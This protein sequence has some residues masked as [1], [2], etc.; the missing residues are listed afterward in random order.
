MLVV[1]S[2]IFVTDTKIISTH[3]FVVPLKMYLKELRKKM[4]FLGLFSF[5]S[6]NRTIQA[7]LYQINNNLKLILMHTVKNINFDL[8][9]QGWLYLLKRSYV[10]C[11]II[12]ITVPLNYLRNQNILNTSDILV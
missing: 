7:T 2:L 11:Y 9:I 3:D 6:F 10:C 5:Y 8:I 4:T 1:L 12:C